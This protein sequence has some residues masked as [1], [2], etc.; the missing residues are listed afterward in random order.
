MTKRYGPTLAVDG[1]SFTDGRARDRL[2]RP[3]RCRQVDDDAADPR[4]R[5]ARQGARSAWA[6]GR[7]PE[8]ASPLREVGALLDAGATHPGRRARDH[9]RWLAAGNRLPRGRVDEVLELVGLTSVARRRTGGF[10]LGMAQRLGIAA[11]LLGDPPILLFDEPVNGLDPQGI[12]WIRELMRSLAAEGRAVLVS[13]HLMSEIEGTADDLVVI[14]RGRL[15]AETTVAELLAG[16]SDG[17]VR[18]RAPQGARV[19]T[20]LA[21]AGGTVTSTGADTLIVTGLDAAEIADL[22]AE[23]GLRLLEL[24]PERTTLEDAFLELTREAVEY[25]AGA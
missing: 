2:R 25:R 3:E 10:S 20:L 8:L 15:I 12:G 22:T 11:A 21:R 7:Y 6:G 1:L 4:P 17:R 16:L 9:L 14:G 19:M 24:S 13:S 23:N 18:L 5:R